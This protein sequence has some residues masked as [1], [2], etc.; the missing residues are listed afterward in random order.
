MRS[1]FRVFFEQP[2]ESA[3]EDRRIEQVVR[4]RAGHFSEIADVHELSVGR[5][6]EHIY[7]SFHCT[8]PDNLTMLRV[9]EVITELEDR[10]KSDCPEIYRVT[11]HP[12]PVT[13]NTR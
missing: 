5:A 4:D 11:I 9:H 6:G 10:V 12:E 13:D 7:L 8:L 3:E 1:S 2:E